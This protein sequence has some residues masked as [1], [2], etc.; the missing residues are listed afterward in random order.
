MAYNHL[1]G[2]DPEL[3]PLLADWPPVS[4]AFMNDVVKVRGYLNT[5][6]LAHTRR[7]LKPKLPPDGAILAQDHQVPV[8]GGAIPVRCYWPATPAG[9]P[10]NSYPLLVWFHGGGYV[11]HSV[12]TDDYPLRILAHALQLAIVNVGYRLAPENPWPIPLDDAHAAVKWAAGNPAT[13]HADLAK[14]FLLAGS[15]AGAHLAGAVAHRI[16]NDSFFDSHPRPTGLFLQIPT[17]VHGD[18]V[19][20]EY[21]ANFTSMEQNKDAPML[22]TKLL[23]SFYP[24]P[25]DPEFSPLLYPLD[26]FKKLPPVYMQVCGLDPV[27]DTGLAYYDKLKAAGVPTKLDTYPGAPH[28]FHMVFPETQAAKKLDVDLRAGIRWLLSGPTSTSGEAD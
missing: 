24:S 7:M 26:S 22:T 23:Y 5:G 20:E 17:M 6:Y 12:E 8:A 25:S 1:A 3:A 18:A 2:P 13:A 14:G 19:P 10:G 15:S 11:Y 27:R 28:G 21:K 4:E 9:E 16:Q